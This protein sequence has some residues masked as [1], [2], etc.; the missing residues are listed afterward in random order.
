[1]NVTTD[2]KAVLQALKKCDRVVVNEEKKMVQIKLHPSKSKVVVKPPFDEK[3][4]KE[5]AD[6]LLKDHLGLVDI[7][8]EVERTSGNFVVNLTSDI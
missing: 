7:R 1:M 6:S 2:E 4:I 5:L 8:T 3:K